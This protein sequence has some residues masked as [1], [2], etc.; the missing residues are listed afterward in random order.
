VVVLALCLALTATGHAGLVNAEDAQ[1]SIQAEH[2][3]GF[4]APLANPEDSDHVRMINHQGGYAELVAVQRNRAVAYSAGELA[5]LDI[6]DPAHPVRLGY[7]MLPAGIWHLAIYG[8]MVFAAGGSLYIIDVSR[9]ESPARIAEITYNGT[10]TG[11]AATARRIFLSVEPFTRGDGSNIPGSVYIFDYSI[12]SAPVQVGYYA[13]PRDPRGLYA[14]DQYVYLTVEETAPPYTWGGL[15]ILDVSNPSNPVEM[16][17]TITA[18][19]ARDVVVVGTTAYV[20]DRFSGLWIVDVSDPEY[21]VRLS[22]VPFGGESG[23]LTIMDG[24]AYVLNNTKGVVAVDVRDPT[25]PEWVGSSDSVTWPLLDYRSIA[26]GGQHV[27]VGGGLPALKILDAT[28]SSSISWVGSY[29]GP[30]VVYDFEIEGSYLYA[31]D[32]PLGLW[33]IDKSDPGRLVVEGVFSHGGASAV[34]VSAGYAYVAGWGTLQAIDISQPDAPIGRASVGIT[35][36]GKDIEI[37]GDTLYLADTSGLWAFDISNPAAP[38]AVDGYPGVEA[39]SISF[40]GNYLYLGAGEGLLLFDKNDLSTPLKTISYVWQQAAISGHRLYAVGYW[41]PG[42]DLG[43][44]IFDISD[45]ANPL[46][47][48]FTEVPCFLT[49]LA[50][51]GSRVYVNCVRSEGV[52]GTR[53]PASVRVYDVEDAEAV[54]LLGAFT[55]SDFDLESWEI[56]LD[57]RFIYTGLGGLYVFEYGYRL[58]GIVTDVLGRPIDGVS[59]SAGEALPSVTTPSGIYQMYNLDAGA[60]TVQPAKTGFVFHPPSRTVETPGDAAGINFTLLSEPVSAEVPPD[61]DARLIYTDTQGLPTWFDFPAGSVPISRTVYITPTIGTRNSTLGFAGH[62]FDVGLYIAEKNGWD[63]GFPLPITVTIHFSQADIAVIS[64]PEQL[65]LYYW[66]GLA[67]IPGRETC[68]GTPGPSLDLEGGLF[69][70]QVCETGKYA[71]YGPT[72]PVF[73]PFTGREPD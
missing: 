38:V 48:G 24:Y 5:V 47:I 39:Y 28:D 33:I 21:P 45:P 50:V 31:A 51:Y 10:P 43:F 22:S 73:L 40:S 34:G 12:P 16:S 32:Y 56:T 63:T 61:A 67:W 54:H 27:Y 44:Y 57:D 35:G 70:L 53:I 60:H 23:E 18:R 49:G 41:N 64:A 29:G 1:S 14:T 7:T 20:S 8:D 52:D 26:A 2:P 13:T 66:N 25:Q 15:T 59:V 30:G 6:S 42:P 37:E 71:L 17:F 11:V 58:S 46:E 19:Y 65:N 4:P 69:S 55:A 3:D 68:A 62:A 36:E 9:P 72:H